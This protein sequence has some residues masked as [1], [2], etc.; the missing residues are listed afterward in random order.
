LITFIEWLN[1][2]YPY[3]LDP[4]NVL[5]DEELKRLGYGSDII[6]KSNIGTGS[7]A[8]STVKNKRPPVNMTNQT[9]VKRLAADLANQKTVIGLTQPNAGNSKFPSWPTRHG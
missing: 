9:T 3:G 1:E 6:Q 4:E 7:G 8:I 5:D 2:N